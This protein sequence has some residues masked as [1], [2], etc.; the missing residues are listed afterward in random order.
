MAV[1]LGTHASYQGI[2]CAAV[3]FVRS[4][5][6]G[7]DRS[8]VT[9]PLSRF[10]ADFRALAAQA[11]QLQ[12]QPP[13]ELP[14]NLAE[15]FGDVERSPIPLGDLPDE[16][17]YEGT[18][19]LSED[20][21]QVVTVPGLVVTRAETEQD[22]DTG[23]PAFV[24]LTLMDWRL[25]LSRGALGRWSFNALRQDGAVSTDTLK[26]DGT[27]YSLADVAQEVA[28]GL[29]RKPTLE[30]P[31]GWAGLSREVVWPAWQRSVTALAELAELGG[32][33]EP[34]LRLDGVLALHMAGK[35]VL[36][37]APGGKGPNSQPIPKEY[38]LDED[39]R[40]Q[41]WTIE[42][43]WPDEFLLFVGR[44][45]VASVALDLW[46]PV[47]LIEGSPFFLS[48]EL[49]RLLTGDRYGL[50]WLQKW[51]LLP[52]SDQDAIGVD[53][54]VVELFR[55]QAYRLWRLPG[56]EKVKLDGKAEDPLAFARELE[57]RAERLARDAAAQAGAPVEGAG[58]D[59]A[60][61]EALAKVAKVGESAQRGFY[62][63]EPG[64]NAHLLPLLYRAETASGRRLPVTVEAWGWELKR[65][66]F[67]VAEGTA[68]LEEVRRRQQQIRRDTLTLASG[69]G[70]PLARRR[71]P[72]S[73]VPPVIDT[74][75]ALIRELGGGKVRGLTLGD[76]LG[77][78]LLPAGL[79]RER[80]EHYMTELRRVALLN[81][82]NPS[83]G[84]AYERT[85]DDEARARSDLGSV[86]TE[87]LALAKKLAG[88]ESEA[89]KEFVTEDAGGAEDRAESLK[90][91]FFAQFGKQAREAAESAAQE[92]RKKQR[93][94]RARKEAGLGPAKLQGA[95]F[96]QNRRRAV[97]TSARVVSAELG[98]VRTSGLAGI[99]RNP[100][101]HDPIQTSLQPM[102]VRVT[103]G[104]ELR[105]RVD[106]PQGAPIPTGTS[107]GFEAAAAFL[108]AR[109]LASPDNR[110]P[111]VLSERESFYASAWRRT[112]P[113]A[114][115][116]V[117][118]DELPLDRATRV[119]VSW[120]ELVPL[121]GAGNVG[122]LDEQ[123]RRIALDMSRRADE[124]RGRQQSF[125]GPWPVQTDGLVSRV[126]IRMETAQGVPCGFTTL[127]TIGGTSTVPAETG[128]RERRR[129]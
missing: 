24:R 27:P 77:G 34:C 90:G 110:V 13:V 97:D 7:A 63:G 28:A 101:V 112:G 86:D 45:R 100:G 72:F 54:R 117:P 21:E 17:R 23:G 8:Q 1:G 59:A 76:M 89:A 68:K 26:P 106:R 61:A 79:D 15:S 9:L 127:V 103:F 75:S 126:E 118:L 31:E 25:F 32:A 80:I 93:E 104:A 43:A 53:D 10:G 98:I 36:G 64:A 22:D 55:E 49:V 47:L 94:T 18:L 129:A 102:P 124:E 58:S 71:D 114:V 116:R 66:K 20:G 46:E 120:R 121:T 51:V 74:D 19:V 52:G 48:E 4:R 38:W 60:L 84:A 78:G 41:A 33:S 91:K 29:W 108:E 35:G 119:P 56:A 30:V 83:L 123:A 42:K 40:G 5:G 87:S 92:G 96:V 105:P 57:A 107:F 16:L 2:P 109:A 70:N 125:A 39:G 85:L 11:A 111:S 122:E 81:E 14:E 12:Q 6:Y 128:T 73:G 67:D 113:G 99:V 115:E 50:V 69:A 3:R 37:Y 95:V 62:T 88:F 65:R 44:P 82:L